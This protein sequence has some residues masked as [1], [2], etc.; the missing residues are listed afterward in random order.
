MSRVILCLEARE[1]SYCIFIFVFFV[2]LFLKRGV[3]QT[4]L[5]NTNNFS[6]DPFDLY[7]GHQQVLPLRVR[8]DLEVMKEY[9]TLCR[10]PELEL[11]H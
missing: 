7:T 1:L 4:V 10:S 6:T 8:V 2:E 11:H 5:S 3:L 9:S